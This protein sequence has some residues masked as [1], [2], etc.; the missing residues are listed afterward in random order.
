MQQRKV[1]TGAQTGA[2][3]L[4]QLEPR[5]LLSTAL[6]GDVL[7]ILTDA[8]ADVI[9]LSRNSDGSLTVQENLNTYQF[10]GSLIHKVSISTGSGTDRVQASGVD[11]PLEVNLGAGN[12]TLVSGAGADVI[13]SG[14]GN[15]LISAG[16]GDNVVYTDAGTDR[17]ITGAGN[18]TVWSGSRTDLVNTGKGQNT[19]SGKAKTVNTGKAAVYRP[20]LA[21]VT[22]QPGV[23]Q[24]N[25]TG[26]DPNQIRT[27][28]GFGDFDPNAGAGQT[29]YIV[30]AFT[31]CMFRKTS[32]HSATSL[33]FPSRL[34][35]TSRS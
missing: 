23:F 29:I 16:D 17:V 15:D 26:Y 9:Q 4:E 2:A 3:K 31:A 1:R 24:E 10:D 5:Q 28:Y 32:P 8:G 33:I 34:P 20:M 6:D 19:V 35:T 11:I 7:R 22:Y 27:A 21:N 13:Y 12:D 18:D 30:D 14:R 25:V